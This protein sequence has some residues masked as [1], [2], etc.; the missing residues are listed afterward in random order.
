MSSNT[1]TPRVTIPMKE[2]PCGCTRQAQFAT[3]NVRINEIP[4]AR[5]AR[6]S[7]IP[8]VAHEAGTGLD[9]RHRWQSLHSTVVKV[10]NGCLQGL[11]VAREE[12]AKSRKGK[13]RRG[14]GA[15]GMQ[16]R[17]FLEQPR[18]LRLNIHGHDWELNKQKIVYPIPTFHDGR[19]RLESQISLRKLN[20]ER[21]FKNFRIKF[22]TRIIE[23]S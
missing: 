17:N 9:H 3:E 2:E 7:S 13:L 8:R 11:R 20:L 19:S 10:H 5:A 6:R 18:F 12:V 21:D 23:V 15:N 16:C 4:F 1:S 22:S 14:R